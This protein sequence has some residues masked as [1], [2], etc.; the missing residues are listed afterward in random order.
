MGLH[1]KY[2]GHIVIEPPLAWQEVEFLRSFGH[3][4]H[5]DSGDNGVRIAAHPSDNEPQD[6]V[7]AYNRPAPGMPG[8]WCPWTVCKDGCCLHWDG[9]ETVSYT[10]LT[11][12]TICS[13]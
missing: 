4:R 2:V 7:G 11:L 5:W 8:L 9:V 10:H 3:T 6:D 13:V 12:P 1:T